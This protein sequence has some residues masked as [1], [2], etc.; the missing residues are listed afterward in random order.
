MAGKKEASHSSNS[1]SLR[2]ASG[3][4]EQSL[5]ETQKGQETPDQRVRSWVGPAEGVSQEVPLVAQGKQS[6]LPEKLASRGVLTRLGLGVTLGRG[7]VRLA[8]ASPGHQLPLL[9]LLQVS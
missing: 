5:Q 9:H 3:F 8:G 4:R 6:E 2:T 7:S 1:I